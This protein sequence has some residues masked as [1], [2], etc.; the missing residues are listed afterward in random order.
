[1]DKEDVVY[2]A[3]WVGIPAGAATLENIMEVPQKAKNRTSLYPSIALLGNYPQDTGVLFQRDACTP[4]FRAA[5]S[6]IAK[7]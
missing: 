6:T 4:M 3:L 7:L 1:M 5:L 2:F